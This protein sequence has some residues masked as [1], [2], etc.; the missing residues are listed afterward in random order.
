MGVTGWSAVAG[1]FFRWL[2]AVAVAA[3]LITA[4]TPLAGVVAARLAMLDGLGPAD[5]IV[6]LGGGGV[7]D[8]GMPSDSSLRRTVRGIA[9]FHRGLAP[10][11][12]LSGMPKEVELRVAL[13]REL[14]VPPARL[15]T[16]DR[17]HTTR[18][19]ALRM[20]A[21][22]HP[23]GI[24]TI[25]L[26]SGSQHLIRARRLFERAEFR[27]LPAVAD[28]ADRTPMQPA[29]RLELARVVTRELL[30]RWYYRLKSDL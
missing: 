1:R 10:I 29:E 2:G 13:A 15:L 14:G 23:R 22:L 11:L 17:S 24:R 30:A 6:V 7:W 4:F 8:D 21:L 26:V 27:V 18:D 9:L 20:A 5:A 16:D 28:E 12:V 19:E 3:F 25:L